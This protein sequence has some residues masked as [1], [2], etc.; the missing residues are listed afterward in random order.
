M[1]ILIYSLEFILVGGE[2]RL[3]DVHCRRASLAYD[4][5]PFRELDPDLCDILRSKSTI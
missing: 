4:L 3:G 1:Y 5:F 2:S